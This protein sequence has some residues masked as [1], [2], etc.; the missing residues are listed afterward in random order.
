MMTV[1]PDSAKRRRLVGRDQVAQFRLDEHL[2]VLAN[3]LSRNACWTCPTISAVA[4]VA[5]VGE[6][7]TLS[8]SFRKSRSTRPRRRNSE[9]MPLKTSRVCQ[10]A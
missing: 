7:E 8:S 3:L 4:A 9:A 2:D 6:V 5:H 10:P 1:G